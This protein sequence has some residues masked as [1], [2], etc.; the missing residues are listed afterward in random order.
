MPY[1]LIIG[2]AY[3]HEGRLITSLPNH[4]LCNKSSADEAEETIHF[5]LAFSFSQMVF[6]LAFYTSHKSG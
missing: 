6:H 4:S 2:H 1:C 5:L 3:A